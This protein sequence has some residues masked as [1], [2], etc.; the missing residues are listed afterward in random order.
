MQSCKATLRWLGH[1][2]LQGTN[3]GPARLPLLSTKWTDGI[4]TSCRGIS[5]HRQPNQHSH[6][7]TLGI[8]PT[9]N[10]QDIKKRFYELSM[11]YHPDRNQGN[12]EAHSW[13]VKFS[14]AYDVL[15]DDRK[16]RDHDRMLRL[17]HHRHYQQPGRSHTMDNH[18][19]PSQYY[20]RQTRSSP[21]YQRNR[22]ASWTYQ[23]GYARPAGETAGAQERDSGSQSQFWTTASRARRWDRN[24]PFVET[25]NKSTSHS[26]HN[27]V[28]HGLHD[29]PPSD[30]DVY[31]KR[32]SSVVSTLSITGGSL[33]VALYVTYFYDTH[34]KTEPSQ[35]IDA[36][37][38]V[39][40]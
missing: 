18:S 34:M 21:Q 40:K 23:Q 33:L 1:H 29:L 2:G 3:A 14:E 7:E 36:T 4:H 37:E 11:Q 30:L 13:F 9:A 27:N 12:E 5:T 28:Y 16:R 39:D 20:S 25:Q 22:S 6:Y 15:R 31:I 17:H 32:V 35:K 38:F 19:R 24:Y 10:R 8:H 26:D